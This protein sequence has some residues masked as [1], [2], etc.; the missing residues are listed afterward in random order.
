[1]RTIITGVLVLGLVAAAA[2]EQEWHLDIRDIAGQAKLDLPQAIAKAL[3]ARPGQALTA[4]LEGEVE[5]GTTTV[6]YEV[7]ILADDGHLYEVEI[8]PGDGHVVEQEQEGG[9]WSEWYCRRF[10]EMARLSLEQLLERAATKVKGRAVAVEVELE[11]GHPIGEVVVLN[12]HDLIELEFE[13]RAGDL[14]EIELQPLH[15]ALEDDDDGGDDDEGE[16]E[17]VDDDEGEDDEGED[18]E[19]DDD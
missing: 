15:E 3:E 17:G 16:D 8:D 19:A 10:L 1:M 9:P 14:L 12:E 5:D 7:L 11:R 4:Q 13:L 2:A 6:V 18:E